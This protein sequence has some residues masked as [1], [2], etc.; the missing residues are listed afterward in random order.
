MKGASSGTLNLRAGNETL[1][2]A[3]LTVEAR[4]AQQS[5]RT[6]MAPTPAERGGAFPLTLGTEVSDPKS[7]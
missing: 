5:T 1:F 7:A 6:R 2:S 4:T 3:W